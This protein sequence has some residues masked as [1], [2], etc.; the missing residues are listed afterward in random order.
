M[1]SAMISGILRKKLVPAKRIIASA[2]TKETADRAAKKFGIHTTNDNT[3]VASQADVLFL[4]VKPAYMEEIIYGISRYVK[5]DCIVV[6]MA[7]GKTIE[8]TARTFGHPVKI[9][10]TMPNTP[11][12]VGEGMTALCPNA[13]ITDDDLRTV[14][15]VFES[16]GRADV[17]SENMIDAVTGVSGS[18]PAYVFM[19]IEALADA[20]VR[21]GMP[22]AQAYEFAAQ[23]VLG[24]AKMVL[25]S[26]KHPGELKDEVCSPGGTT[27][28]AVKVLE[29]KGFRGAV[30]D[31]ALACIEKAG[32]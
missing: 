9:V 18:S 19:F 23:T 31:A 5:K 25:E 27:I 22:R 15:A 20:G 28:E 8:W 29:E 32:R 2:R 30:I 16:F 13:D 10:R 11:A 4:A 17:V 14:K 24:S 7:P 3:D 26:G 6:T 21:A 12:A 1:A